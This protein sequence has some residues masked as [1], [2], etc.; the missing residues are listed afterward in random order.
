M[1]EALARL[2]GLLSAHILLSAAA[3]LLA[4]AISLPL[5]VAAARRPAVARIALGAASLIQTIP[6]LALLALFYP[7]LLGLSAL[8]GGG[9][10]AL[11]FLPSLLAL[12]LYALL[13]ILR[14]AV[15]GLTG[16][17]QAIVEA[18]DGVGMTAGQKL[19]LVEA[20]LAA[21]VVMAGIRT[22]AVWTI[23]A[24]TLS[25]TVG[26]PGLGDL[27]FA[28]LQT[29]DWTLVLTGCLASAAL[30]LAVDALL[31]AVAWGLAKRRR[32]AIW[33]GL[34]LLAA[35]IAAAA[36]PRLMPA[37]TRDTVVIGAKNFGEQYILARLIGERLQAAGYKV[38]YREGLG[39]AVIFR[40]L[41]AGDIDVYVDY[42][43]TLWTNEMKRTDVPS[44]AAMVAAIGD[45]ARR[46]RGVS[47]I[48]S[49][50]FEN[51]YALAVRGAD[52]K[53]LGLR[54]IDDLARVSPDM[55]LGADLEFLER[56]E[57]AMLR[58]AYPLRFAAT[59]AYSPT[60]MFRAIESG[61]AD[62]IS[63]FSSDGRI[64]AMNL[65]VLEDPKAA[66]PGYDAIL[67]AAPRRAGDARFVRALRPLV[68]AIAVETMR[69]ANYHVDR[70]TDKQSPL[71]AARW[72]DAR[73][74]AR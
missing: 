42:S 55:T 43:G 2:P 29:Q 25:T 40:A 60:F 4:L 26:Q 57:W 45:W 15:T 17:D 14:N 12:T 38:D 68:G 59:R 47:L 19:R 61:Q 36:L 11:G 74:R 44:R 48:G 53:R 52:A 51:A 27:I 39:S 46:G 28:G 22:A 7:V 30:A 54:T 20:P 8:V 31:G 1:S 3:L 73:I 13:P 34:T 9:I 58:R 72:L 24:A 62:A 35:G 21:P 63:A 64:A 32:V 49:L 10:P 41:A 18:A 67:L 33:V 70:T 66:I 65:R 50:G 5:A 6:A 69:Q 23:G 37:P 56:P 71:A 16:L